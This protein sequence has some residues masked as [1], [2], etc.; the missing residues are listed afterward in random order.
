LAGV[1]ADVELGE[2]GDEL[3]RAV[4]SSRRGF[5]AFGGVLGD[6]GGDGAF[7]QFLAVVEVGGSDGADVELAAEGEG[8]GA[9]VDDRAVD[10][11]LGGGG[12]DGVGEEFGC[13]PCGWWGV[14][15]AGAVDADDCVEVDGSALLVFGDLGEGDAGVVAE[16]ALAQA[17]ALGDLAAE[18]DREAPPEVTCV[19][20]PEDG[21]FVVV[22]VGVE[23]GAE[24][25][26]VLVV[27][28]A[29]AAW[30]AVGAAVVDRAEARGGEGS[31]DA[32]VSGDVFRGALAAAQSG[33]DQVEGVAAVD[34]GAG[35]T[36]GSAAVV[37][38]DEELAGGEAGRVEVLEGAADLAGCR[39]DGVFGA[40][41]VE[42]D[43]VGAAAEAGELAE[44]TGEG[45]LRGQVRE[46]RQGGRG[47]AGEDGVSLLTG[48]V[49][50][51]WPRGGVMLGRVPPPRRPMGFQRRL[52]SRSR[53]RRTTAATA[54][55][56]A[57]TATAARSAVRTTP[58][59]TRATTVF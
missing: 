6:V 44:D 37:A 12:F 27:V 34:L 32:R 38:A 15:S 21:G 35:R 30:A 39:V 36:A 28:E 11:D 51:N 8:V 54:T 59:T 58:P 19:G 41:A 49:G 17:C 7:G 9:A 50:R 31:E 5:G 3:E 14:A 1:V 40:V 16:A 33:G 20:V 29:A 56:M 42:A 24:G 4:E 26:V 45:A 57:V 22:G 2:F 18:V 46:F 43:G 10:A 13:G 53:E 55:E 23:R 25:V 48:S 52:W 47:G